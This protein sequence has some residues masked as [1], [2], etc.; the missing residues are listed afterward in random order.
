M[1]AGRN[2]SSTVNAL[3]PPGGRVHKSDDPKRNRY[4]GASKAAKACHDHHHMLGSGVEG[5]VDG[6]MHVQ[7]PDA[8][9]RSLPHWTA[10]KEGLLW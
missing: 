4:P 10:M 1:L 9:R 3:S 5:A 2:E 8:R 6:A 7:P